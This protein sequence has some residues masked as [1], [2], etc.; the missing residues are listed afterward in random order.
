MAEPHHRPERHGAHRA[1]P[2]GIDRRSVL[3]SLVVAPFMLAA[4]AADPAPMAGLRRWGN[5]QFRRFGFLVYEATLWASDT[6]PA[7]PLALRLDYKLSVAAR[8]IVSA[9]VTEMRRLGGDDARLPDWAERM[10]RLFPDVRAGDHLI[11]IHRPGGAFFSHN[12][13]DLGGIADPQ[14][15]RRFFAIWLDPRTSAP[16]LRTAL[17]RRP[18]GGA[19]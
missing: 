11:G 12:G 13:R 7:P 17:L 9:S 8:D 18:G 2:Q 5:G 1:P 14:F 3:V 4:A 19:P 16:D 15:A 10:T 6:P